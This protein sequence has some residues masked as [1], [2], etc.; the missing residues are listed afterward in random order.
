DEMHQRVS[1]HRAERGAGWT[2]VETP[3]F[4]SEAIRDIG[5]NA[6]VL[7]VDCLTL[8][9]SN[10]MMENADPD[11]SKDLLAAQ[12]CLLIEILH[13]AACP[14]ILVTNEV[15]AGIVPDNPLARQY[16]DAVGQVNQRIAACADQVIW[17]VAGIP[18]KIK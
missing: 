5:P 4:L 14:V 18:V 13:A 9:V 8:W 7:L 15:G 11:A 1:R 10:L 3:L 6:D 17:M 16:R 2:A 12:T